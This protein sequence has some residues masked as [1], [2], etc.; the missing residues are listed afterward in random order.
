MSLSIFY[1]YKQEKQET[2]TTSGNEVLLGRAKDVPVDIDLYPDL[3]V[4]R[5]HAVLFYELGAWW[6]KDLDS[7]Y[8]TFLREKRITEATELSPGD[9]L[10][11]GDTVL[12]VEFSKLQID[13]APGSV[14]SIHVHETQPPAAVA[15]DRY[16]KILASITGV[17]AHS[18]NAQ[19]ML[20]G[21]LREISDAFPSAERKT[22]IL[23]EEGE[24][25]PRIFW[26]PERAY[27]SFTLARQAVKKKQALHWKQDSAATDSQPA[28]SLMDTIEALYAPI[29]ANGVV[30]GVIHVD[31][32]QELASFTENDLLLL[33]VIANTIGPA[34]K[35]NGGLA[36]I[37][38][39]FI[40]YSHDDRV[41]AGHLTADLRRRGVKVYIDERLQAG[42]SWRQQL[43][44]AIEN[45]DAFVL[46]ISPTS[47]V[48]EYV[49]WELDTAQGLNKKVFPLMYE[50]ASV[51]PAITELQYINIGKDYEKGLDQLAERLHGFC[52]DVFAAAEISPARVIEKS[53]LVGEAKYIL[54][55]SDLHFGTRENAL[56]WH[57][58]LAEDLLRDVL[59]PRLD[60]VILSGDISNRAT[61]E[62]FD[63]ATLFLNKLADEFQLDKRQF[64][65]VPGNHD[66]SW[67]T[68]KNAYKLFSREEGLARNLAPGAYIEDGEKIAIRDE[69]EYQQRFANFD[70][71]YRAV[72]TEPYALE[73]EN[74][75]TLDYFPELDLLVLGLNS[76]WELDHRYTLRAS[77][78]PLAVS[79]ALEQIRRNPKYNN[80]LKMA[81]WHHPLHS[82]AEDRIKASDFMDRLAVSNF[83]VAFHGHIHKAESSIFL[84]DYSR[85]GRKL[86]VVAAGTF[87]APIKEWVPGY[88]LQYNLLKLQDGKLTVETRRREKPD[89]AWQPDARWTQGPGR[90][91]LP[92][93]EIEL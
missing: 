15:E 91:P 73:Y 8:G 93:Y 41:F 42:E 16:L 71:F 81:V 29:L 13:L 46:L 30:V 23:V 61:A 45:T 56:N 54:H 1:K 64:V 62:E 82:A 3:K 12:R 28:Q 60:G 57:S 36:R 35:N 67:D 66:L 5:P 4:S 14:E 26:P 85:Q 24:L 21:F 33:S 32:T 11:L 55:L 77:I 76:A 83:R 39:V 58:Q 51:P 17:V 80:C 20:E 68:S 34:L 2:Y 48:S 6:V 92:R 69:E 9:E 52:N 31:T 49:E 10:R 89:G 44:V 65:L 86:N 43:A 18:K 75:Y 40:S 90:D 7:K 78:H 88:P 72:K 74:Q 38:A 87:G 70:R 63:A 84:Y 22:I 37:P 25:V 47:I 53:P 79:N 27:V 50:E 59:C 19:A